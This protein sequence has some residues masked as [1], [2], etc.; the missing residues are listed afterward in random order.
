MG[1]HLSSELF[2]GRWREGAAL[3]RLDGEGSHLYPARLVNFRRALPAYLTPTPPPTALSRCPSVNVS[4]TVD[5]V[6]IPATV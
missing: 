3:K 6:L 5:T 1:T 2:K 4:V